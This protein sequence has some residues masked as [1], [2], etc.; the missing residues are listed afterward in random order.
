MIADSYFIAKQHLVE[1]KR[2]TTGPSVPFDLIFYPPTFE[3]LISG[4]TKQSRVDHV[5][6][7]VSVSV[8]CRACAYTFALCEGG[9]FI[10]GMEFLFFRSGVECH[11]VRPCARERGKV[12]ACLISPSE[13]R[14]ILFHFLV[15]A[16]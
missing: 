9:T 8:P 12:L 2:A 11:A 4:Q 5:P 6:S 16:V 13:G 3:R 14:N 7:I 10:G 1:K 15:E